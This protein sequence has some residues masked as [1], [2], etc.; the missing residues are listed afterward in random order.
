VSQCACCWS[1]ARSTAEAVA[2]SRRGRRRGAWR[3]RPP[4]LWRRPRPPP[5]FVNPRGADAAGA[6]D[7]HV[8]FPGHRGQIGARRGFPQMDKA[9][10]RVGEKHG[11]VLAQIVASK[12]SSRAASLVRS[13]PAASAITVGDGA[14]PAFARCGGAE[15]ARVE[16]FERRTSDWIAWRRNLHSGGEIVLRAPAMHGPST[17]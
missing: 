4:P 3:R 7:D 11:H 13:R 1:Q 9:F 16:S 2:D 14:G 12:S 5:P 10:F 15:R 17:R 6:T 8:R